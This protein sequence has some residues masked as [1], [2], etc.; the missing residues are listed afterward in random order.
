MRVL[1]LALFLF[2]L[3]KTTDAGERL[4]FPG[5]LGGV[6]QKIPKGHTLVFNKYGKTIVKPLHICN[7]N[8]LFDSGRCFSGV[9]ISEINKCKKSDVDVN[10]SVFNCT[11]EKIEEIK[12]KN[13]CNKRHQFELEICEPFTVKNIRT[14]F[15]KI[16]PISRTLNKCDTPGANGENCNKEYAEHCRGRDWYQEQC[17]GPTPPGGDPDPAPHCIAAHGNVQTECEKQNFIEKI[18]TSSGG[19]EGMLKGIVASVSGA[20]SS[21]MD[22]TGK[23]INKLNLSQ[24]RCEKA[25]DNCITTCNAEGIKPKAVECQMKKDNYLNW[26][27]AVERENEAAFDKALACFKKTKSD[28]FVSTKPEGN[29]CSIITDINKGLCCASDS[30]AGR[31]E[32]RSNHQV[33]ADDSDDGTAN[34]IS[35]LGILGEE[36]P[37]DDSGLK[38]SDMEGPSQRQAS[39]PGGSGG[40]GFGGGGGSSGGD[41]NKPVLGQNRKSSKS[42]KIGFYSYRKKPG[43]PSSYNNNNKRGVSNSEPVLKKGIDKNF[44]H[45]SLKNIGRKP[46]SLNKDLTIWQRV[47]KRFEKVCQRGQIKGCKVKNPK[48]K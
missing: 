34:K 10:S 14:E 23:V 2:G 12:V 17:V 8:D 42:D 38:L 40:S 7:P 46:S 37:Y 26:A 9:D 5:G 36:Q 25:Y 32:C 3:I 11:K 48:D 30:N 47:S 31:S 39:S 1:I 4:Y 27:K 35:D 45:N 24:R 16:F 28:G 22:K 6:A 44:V 18:S 29:D 33:G 21:L 13:E 19:L 15:G 41:S 43:F 20:C